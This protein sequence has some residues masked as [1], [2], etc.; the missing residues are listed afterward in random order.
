Q[1]LHQAGIDISEA[2]LFLVLG[3]AQGGEIALFEGTQMTFPVKYAPPRDDAPL[4]VFASR[5]AIFVTCAGASLLG[6]QAD[7]L[8]GE[9]NPGLDGALGIP[10]IAQQDPGATLKP[11]GRM[12]DVQSVLTRARESGRDP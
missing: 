12:L 2:P 10:N 3:K 6:K 7:I 9:S 8:A 5:D 11:E 4:H 1:T